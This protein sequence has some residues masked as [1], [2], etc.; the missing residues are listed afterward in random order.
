MTY[1]Y[2]MPN[3]TIYLNDKLYQRVKKY[4]SKIIKEVLEFISLTG[5]DPIKKKN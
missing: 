3:I 1:F 2:T 4:P 5:E